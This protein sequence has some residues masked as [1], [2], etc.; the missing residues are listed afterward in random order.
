MIR[1]L[2]RH[3]KIETMRV[4]IFS[5]LHL[6]F[7]ACEFPPEVRDGGMADL[8]LLA[9][10]I[11]IRR[12]GPT[13]AAE[14]FTAPVAMILGNHEA[15]GE[16]LYAAIDAQRKSA[17]QAST[18]R[19]HPVRTL[20]RETWALKAADGTPVR[21]IAAT[22]WT[23][24]ALFGGE[25]QARMMD[26]AHSAMN[27][28]QMIGIM[29]SAQREQ[30]PLTPSDCL[31]LHRESRHYIESELAQPFDGVSIVMTHHAPSR[32]SVPESRWGDPI[33]AAYASDLEV[34]IEQRRPQLWVHGH[35]HSSSDYRIG[36]TRV[37]C[38]PR[39]YFPSQLNPGFDPALVV[40][41]A[42]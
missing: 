33:N 5:D 3:D 25:T 13:W 15:Y 38:N 37:I 19:E 36:S 18:R 26:A 7:G 6:E 34:L 20:E 22:L 21:V 11:H 17:A 8:V 30:R 14:T 31:R 10:D 24:F 27:D 29:D 35:I 39:G 28:F 1:A 41:L 42:R 2:S 40:E 16:S 12:R 23:D 32:R 4:H 9:G